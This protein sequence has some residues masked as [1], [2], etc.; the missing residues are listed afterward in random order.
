MRSRHSPAGTKP[1][2]AIWRCSRAVMEDKVFWRWCCRLTAL[3][4][5]IAGV[6]CARTYAELC[7]TFHDSASTFYVAA[8]IATQSLRR[9]IEPADYFAEPVIGNWT[10]KDAPIT[11][12]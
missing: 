11:L 8:A 6:A 1:A 10:V 2:V 9:H 7:M 4:C 5:R 12:F 3:F